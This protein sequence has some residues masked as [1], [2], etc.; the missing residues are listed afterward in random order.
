MPFLLTGGQVVTV[1]ETIGVDVKNGPFGVGRWRFERD[2]INAGIYGDPAVLQVMFN[3]IQSC[4]KLR[5]PLAD[6]PLPLSY[7]RHFRQQF[8]TSLADQVAPL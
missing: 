2:K 6:V 1:F 7:F 4:L 3:G 5:Q 8:L